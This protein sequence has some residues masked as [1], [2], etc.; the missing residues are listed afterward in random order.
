MEALI[1]IAHGSKLKSSNDEVINT[2]ENIKKLKK[3]M[4]VY[5]AFLELAE[6]TFED[7]LNVICNKCEVVKIFPYFLAAGKHVT[8]DIPE[9]LE[10]YKIKYPDIKFLLL[11]HLGN[12]MGIENLIINNS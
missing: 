12:C 4:L 7:I 11:P 1:I 8:K 9:I 5:S 6:P 3:D 10:K 2:V